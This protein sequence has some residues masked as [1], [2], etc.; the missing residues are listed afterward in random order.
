[1]AV[2]KSPKKEGFFCVGVIATAH[3]IKG[4]VNVRSFTDVPEDFVEYGALVS[5]ADAPFSFSNVR[6]AKKGFIASVKGVS[7]RND[8][9]KLR[10]T[11]LYASNEHLP[12]LDEGEVFVND[13]LGMAVQREDG[14]AF[15]K[16]KSH[17][18]NGAHL[19]LTIKMPENGISDVMIPFSDDVIIEIDR[20]ARVLTVSDLADDYA[21]F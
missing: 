10:G 12:E 7:T 15:G 6:P 8:A 19:V 14:S 5:F 16:V 18:D 21:S 2:P 4:E 9:E 3:G 11:F 20:D 13:L 1:M 17:F